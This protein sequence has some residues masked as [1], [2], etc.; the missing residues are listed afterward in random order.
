MSF[1]QEMMT[2]LDLNPAEIA[3]AQQLGILPKP[4]NGFVS[5]QPTP[6]RPD[7][8]ASILPMATAAQG[9]GT[10]GSQSVSGRVGPSPVPGGSEALPRVA[11]T[12]GT[13]PPS[14]LG[15]ALQARREMYNRQLEEA[16]KPADYSQISS[17]MRDRSA[18]SQDDVYAAA[19]AGLGPEATKGFQAPILKQAM[20]ARQPMKVEGGVVDE[21]GRV[22]LDPAHQ[23]AK[24]ADQ[25]RNR[26]AQLDTLEA[27]ITSDAEK[28]A[29]A[30]E[31]NHIMQQIAL[32]RAESSGGGRGGHASTYGFAPDGRR[33]VEDR[34]GN[35]FIINPDNS[36]EPYTGASTPKA[37][38]ENN[39]QAV[40]A[41]QG[42]QARSD[43]LIEMVDK[44]PEA[45][46]IKPTLVSAM[47]DMIQ[48]RVMPKVLTA[49]QLAVR[50][51]VLRQAAVEIHQ[52][53]GAALTMG[54]GHRAS[55]WAIGKN[56]S[57]DMIIS[58]LRSARDW[59]KT[60]QSAQGNAAQEVAAGRTG[61]PSPSA[62][63]APLPG[64]W[65]VR[66][67]PRG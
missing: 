20:E 27:R 13:P 16:N 62:P 5:P 39:A 22:M 65:S 15:N 51:E 45:F 63:A 18:R 64:G 2:G 60:A 24:K 25:L 30:H 53:Y 40:M 66:E 11:L 54:E 32:I 31:R 48:G 67:K 55:Q 33:V 3:E 47:P 49:Q 58:K 21:E 43:K 1:E 12:P 35:Q 7:V 6:S 23:S 36:R 4:K 37:R 26:L 61:A 57:P 28:S 8:P 46:G 14:P 44:N 50:S 56:D 19:L 41:L 34:N 10:R 52:I 42:A 38:F 59:A 29:L 17:Q 9:G